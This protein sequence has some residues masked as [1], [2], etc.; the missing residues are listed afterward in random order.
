MKA[1]LT[2]LVLLFLLAIIIALPAFAEA[3]AEDGAPPEKA[4]VESAPV[5]A[6]VAKE[7]EKDAQVGESERAE[8][9]AGVA[10]LIKK[11]SKEDGNPAPIAVLTPL[12]YTTMNYAELGQETILT[13]LSRYGKFDVRVIDYS[14]AALTLEEF[15]K[16]VTRFDV[17]VVVLCV[18]KPTNFDL[19]IYD[20]RTPYNIYAHSEVLPEA[21]QYQLTKQVVEEYTK[22]IVRR[23]LFA[24]MQDQYFELP[25]EEARPFLNAEIPR[26]VAS[27]LSYQ[28]V[29]REILS[30]YYVS[31]SVGAAMAAGG[32]GLWTSNMVSVQ[33]GTKV[34][35]NY[36]AELNLDF[37]SYNSIGV[38]MK[39]MFA[40]RDNPLRMSM[41]L[42][43]ATLSNSRTINW[44]QKHTQGT[45]GNYFV[46]S[47][48]FSFPIVDVHVKVESKLFVS[49]DGSKFVLSLTPGLFF[50]F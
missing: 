20:R 49:I 21:V 4:G 3:T 5:K 27:A 31:G 12:D 41:G 13:A 7:P 30:R 50:M 10:R 25:R 36:F 8:R 42:G 33:L 34:F 40:N 38:A 16:T 48:A 6:A 35:S 23:A 2:T 1:S 39:Y 46:P 37:F 19:F 14:P 22:V 45:G 47:A 28:T 15:R 29:N 26:F 11:F 43:L 32:G 9:K 44:D 24:Y 18:L 17:D